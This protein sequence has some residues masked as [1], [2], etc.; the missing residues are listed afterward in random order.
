MKNSTFALTVAIQAGES[1]KGGA[2]SVNPES[3]LKAVQ[4]SPKQALIASLGP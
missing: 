1:K 4:R 3:T 2:E